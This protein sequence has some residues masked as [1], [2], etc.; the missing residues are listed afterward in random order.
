MV[1]ASGWAFWRAISA[2]SRLQALRFIQSAWYRL[3]DWQLHN[4][5]D[6]VTLAQSSRFVHGSREDWFRFR[7]AP[8]LEVERMLHGLGYDGNN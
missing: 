6:H 1:F 4:T 2:A 3:A 7:S 8:M 5:K